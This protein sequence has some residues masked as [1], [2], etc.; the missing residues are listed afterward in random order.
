MAIFPG[1]ISTDTDLLVGANFKTALLTDNPLSAGAVTVNVNSTSGFPTVGALLIDS[2]LIKYTGLTGTSFTG[3]TRGFDGT[4]GASHVQNS[5]V[6]LV[7]IAFHHNGLKD[8]IKAIEQF[9]SDIIGRTNTQVQ[10]PDGTLALPGI[11]FA[12]QTGVGIYRAGSND[13]RFVAGGSTYLKLAGTVYQPQVQVGNLDGSNS[14]PSYSFASDSNTGLFR[15]GADDVR[16]AAG[17]VGVVKWT[18]SGQESFLQHFFADG[19]VSLPGI[20]FGGDPDSGLYRIAANDFAIAAGGVRQ[21][22]FTTGGVFLSNQLSITDGTA[23]SPGL[24]F[25]SDTNTGIFRSSN[26]RISFSTAG[27]IRGEFT[28][29]GHFVPGSD[30]SYLLGVGTLGWKAIYV[31][32]G[33]VSLP[34]HSFSNDTDC[35]LFRQGTNEVRMAANGIT[36]FSWSPNDVRFWSSGVDKIQWNGTDF[37]PI[38]DN[39]IKLGKTGQRWSEVWAANGTIQTSH[40]STK[41]DIVDVEDMEVPRG[42]MYN[43]DGRRFL[44]YLNDSLPLEGRPTGDLTANYEQAV[45]G[46]LCSAVRKL[47]AEV[48]ALKGN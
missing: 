43:R 37:F 30:N 42:V 11:S 2:E 41:T 35:G 16:M 45:I 34:S 24:Q 46:V 26:D 18:A 13:F 40:S 20:T 17:G 48:K 21:I 14:T 3:C 9:I 33:T 19:T 27:S 10:A 12:G 25:G 39:A 32:D 31:A 4:T 8:E 29:L 23:S 28:D 5:Q 44:G 36:Q 38:A 22:E 7:I 15:Q 6:R 1:A 47:Q